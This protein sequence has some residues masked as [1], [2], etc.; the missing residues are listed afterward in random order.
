MAPREDGL[1]RTGARNALPFT[2]NQRKLRADDLLARH[3]HAEQILVFYINLLEVQE[4][5]AKR[6]LAAGWAAGGSPAH[7]NRLPVDDL[8]PLLLSFLRDVADFGTRTLGAL[9]QSIASAGPD[10]HVR[11][12]RH[13]LAGK[14]LDD[15]AAALDCEPAQL[16]F[17]PRA[18]IQPVADAMARHSHINSAAELRRECP[19]CG[20]L[21]QVAVIRDEREIKGRRSLICSLCSTGWSYPRLTCPGCG[22]S[23]PEKLVYHASDSLPHLRIEEC[24]TCRSYLKSV[25]LRQD[26]RAVPVVDEIASVELDLWAAERGLRKVERNVVGL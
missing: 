6:A 23:D 9:A 13:Y 21:P 4:P 15:L 17:F 20:R 19:A 7:L 3:P 5:I 25:D 10:L 1:L 2:W 11:L 14:P 26:G 16:V 24:R 8:L 18:L 12:L 22:E